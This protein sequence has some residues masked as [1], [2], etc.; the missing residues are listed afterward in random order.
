M[1]ELGSA[2]DATLGEP[3]LA[4]PKGMLHPGDVR[5]PHGI[6]A[7]AMLALLG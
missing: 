3:G 5:V 1:P 7:L 6:T 4:T 2:A